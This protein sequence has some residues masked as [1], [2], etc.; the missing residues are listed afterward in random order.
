MFINHV[1][2]DYDNDGEIGDKDIEQTIKRLV[3]PKRYPSTPVQEICKG[4]FSLYCT[5]L[6]HN[7]YTK[8]S[9]KYLLCKGLCRQTDLDTD[10][11]LSFSE[12]KTAAAKN[13]EFQKY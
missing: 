6:V 5:L 4:S 9:L 11:G 2:L 10:D 8:I 1:C 7:F 3:G 12:F 13:L